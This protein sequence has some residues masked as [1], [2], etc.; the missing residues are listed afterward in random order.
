[1][2]AKEEE[3]KVRETED[4]NDVVG[5]NEETEAIEFV[6]FQVSECYVYLIPPRKSAASYRADEWNVNKWAWEGM[7]KVVSKGEE[8]IIKLEDKSTGELYARAFLRKGE[9]H[10]VEPV[11]DSSR[12]FVLRIEE[13][14]GGR[15]RHAFIGIG[16]RERTEAYDF[17]AALHDHMKYLDKKK[18]AEEME[19]QFQSTSAV[20]YSLKEGETLHL[21]LKNKSSGRVK[22]KFFEQGLNDLSLD[23]KGNRKESM[24]CLKP[25][26]PPPAPLSPATAARKS[27]SNSPRKLS[28]EGSSKDASPD[29]TKEDS[30]EQHSP[31]SPST[32][33]IPD[34]DFG[35]FQA[36]G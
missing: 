15:L 28:L 7:L 2:M 8:C 25:L 4:Q 31:E 32:E 29:S 21:H 27:P 22:S 35:D 23:D 36:A 19:Q 1:M 5:E 6:L 34:D 9:L 18:T 10:P 20:D 33:D 16:F 14:I 24:I 11:I 26:P 17:Q 30:N 3:K 13:N 12:Y